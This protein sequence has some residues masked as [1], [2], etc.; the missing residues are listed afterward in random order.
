MAN[1]C[2]NCRFPLAASASFCPQ[3]GRPQ[4]MAQP[5]PAANVPAAAVSGGGTTMKIVLVVVCCIVGLGVAAAAAGYYAFHKVKEAVVETAAKNGVD[6]SSI[7]SPIPSSSSSSSHKTYKPCEI[8]SKSEASSLLGQPIERTAMEE[9][10]CEYY[11]PPGLSAKLA[12]QYNA[13]LGKQ[14]NGGVDVT[15]MMSALAA[16]STTDPNGEIPLLRFALDPDGRPQMTALAVSK[17]LFGGIFAAAAA[18]N[19]KGPADQKSDTATFGANIPNLGD[20]AMFM[21][22]LGLN[23]LKGNTVMRIVVGPVPAANDKAIAIARAVL[24]RI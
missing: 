24:P 14:A 21:P 22:P 17:G 23:V 7:P 4:T 12:T 18:S 8:L 11:G 9:Q 2:S 1:F 6:L 5:A 10:S 3:C 16:Q 19:A 15:K 13:D 20:Q